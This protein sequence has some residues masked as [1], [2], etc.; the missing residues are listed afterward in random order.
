MPDRLKT[1]TLI[2]NRYHYRWAVA[3]ASWTTG[4]MYRAGRGSAAGRGPG[5]GP[6]GGGNHAETADPPR[7]RCPPLP[8]G[9]IFTSA[10][11][12]KESAAGHSHGPPRALHV[13]VLPQLIM[14]SLALGL[15]L[16]LPAVRSRQ[17]GGAGPRRGL[18]RAHLPPGGGAE[19][20]YH[21]ERTP[22]L[23]CIQVTREV[24][25]ADLGASVLYRCR[26]ATYSS[27]IDDASVGL[28]IDT[29]RGQVR[30][31]EH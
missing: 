26:R 4:D 28:G 30:V 18:P 15:P 5:G 31:L 6:G 17:P 14:I 27:Y 25:L 21:P 11:S 13:L 1:W 3:G 2:S 10:I 9:S 20:P 8:L 22:L 29:T 12:L 24:L 19:E 7:S 16:G 23:K